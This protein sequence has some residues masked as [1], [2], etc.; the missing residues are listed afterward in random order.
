MTALSRRGVLKATLGGFA[1]G[2]YPGL[3][4]AAPK[5]AKG[6]QP[7]VFVHLSPDGAVTLT[8]HRSEMGQGIRST[9]AYLFAGELGADLARVSIEQAVGDA[10]YG[11]QN[12]DGSSSIRGKL[13]WLRRFAATARVMLLTAAAERWEVPV[14][15][16]EAKAHFVVNTL[17]G[18][19]L[20]FG[21]LAEAAGKLPV[22]ADD[23]VT[24]LPDAA[25]PWLGRSA[26]SIDAQSF[27][28]GAAQFGADVTLPGML[29]AV[30]AR[31]PVVGGRIKRLDARAALKVPGVKKVLALPTPRAPWGFQPW[32]GVAV[33]ATN[34][35]AAIRGRAA[36]AIDWEHGPNASY[37][38][39]AFR[40]GLHRALQSPGVT[41]REVGDVDRALAG[42]ARIIEAEYDVPHLPHSPMEPPVALARFQRGACEVWASTQNPQ[43]ARKTVAETLGLPE[44]KVT[45]HVTLL[46]GGFGRKSKADFCAEAA[47]L[48]RAV[49]APVRVQWTREDD[50]RHDY[51]NTV[52]A[53]KLTAGIDATGQ[54]VA[55]R[56]RTAFPPISTLYGGP[57]VPGPGDLQQGV[58]DLAL[59]VPNVR[60][61]GCEA[62]GAPVRIGWLRA[63]YNLFH[64]FA[65]GSFIDE[66]AH[67]RKEDPR[68]TWLSVLGPP[69]HA[70]LR[71]LGIP[72]LKNYNASLDEHPVDVARLRQVLER[73]TKASGWEAGARAGPR[74]APQLPQLRGGRGVGGASGRAHRGRRGV[75]GH[76]RRAHRQPRPRALPDG[77]L[78][79]VRPQPRL[80]R[81]PHHERRGDA[82]VELP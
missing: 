33:L 53:Q 38:S 70:S 65:V 78:G 47:W 16:C 77:G 13:D 67:A 3:G 49:K 40:D 19:K 82:A 74:R 45:V 71:E 8:V 60:A 35:W 46:G 1:L 23:A 43:A 48:A 25:H 30:I 61:E 73:V 26:P 5:R 63:V 75:A 59:A 81:R 6:L 21:E 28:T 15:A 20:S 7:N 50:V 54:L 79:G 64:A 36:L 14:S 22:P 10:A 18:A 76:R 9:L 32:G 57:P 44:S 58:L 72:A 27:V 55:W 24:L 69:R 68:A 17:T 37:D 4:A 29:I 66:L 34:T 62:P 31:P 12:T 39:A 42:A 51:Y 11:D 52:S 41:L 2:L 80:L 56:H